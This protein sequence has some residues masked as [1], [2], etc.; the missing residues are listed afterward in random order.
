M[1]QQPILDLVQRWSEAEL[2][3]DLASYDELLAADFLGVGPVGFVLAKPEWI[4]RFREGL[5]NHEIEIQEPTV[6]CYGDDTAVVLAVQRQRSTARGHEVAGSFRVTLV[7][8]SEGPRWTIANIQL[9]GPIPPPP[10]GTPAHTQ[11]ERPTAAEPGP[12]GG[13][14]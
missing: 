3:G 2:K 13:S 10:F 11:Q 1:T 14:R 7:A 4:G 12:S 6:R 8:V 9:S 5:T